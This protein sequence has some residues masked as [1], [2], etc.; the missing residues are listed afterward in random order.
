MI[1]PGK[2]E[3]IILTE[4][5]VFQ[6]SNGNYVLYDGK[7]AQIQ[8]PKKNIKIISTGQIITLSRDEMSLLKRIVVSLR[9]GSKTGK[10]EIRRFP[11][12]YEQWQRCIDTA[13]LD[14]ETQVSFEVISSSFTNRQNNTRITTFIAILLSGAHKYTYTEAEVKSLLDSAMFHAVSVATLDISGAL[15]IEQEEIDRWWEYNRYFEK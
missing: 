4:K 12:K 9:Y 6:L 3:S 5:E 15:I 14:S 10:I 7:V 2:V 11:L 8:E 13:I 1:R